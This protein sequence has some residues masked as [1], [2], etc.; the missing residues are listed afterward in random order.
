MRDEAPFLLEWIAYHQMIGFEQFVVYSNHCTDGTDLL[1]DEIARH[2]PLCHRRHDPGAGS[3][4]HH[5]AGLFMQSG[6]LAEGDW[7]MWLDPDEFLNVKRGLGNLP[8]LLGLIGPYQGMP[9][10]WRVFGDANRRF[11]PGRQISSAFTWA[12]RLHRPGKRMLKTLCRVG[13]GLDRLRIHAPSMTPEF[14]TTSRT[15]LS[16]DGRPVDLADPAILRWSKGGALLIDAAEVSWDIA[17][18]NHYHVRTEAGFALKHKRGCGSVGSAIHTQAHEKY[19]P[20][21]FAANNPNIEE[22]RSILRH[23]P[24]LNRVMQGLL[25]T[26]RI[27]EMQSRIW[28]NFRAHEAAF[29][30][31]SENRVL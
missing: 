26:G 25:R 3:A 31:E 17:Q 11:H 27:G 10:P 14:W 5:G 8:D 20:G 15:F 29:L 16:S 21:R 1:L 13:P 19:A 23:E 22:D 4:Q 2:L 12:E 28:A 9:V 24:G 30:A 7:V 6:F 18:V